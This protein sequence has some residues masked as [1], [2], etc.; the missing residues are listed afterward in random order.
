[1]Q[2]E[3]RPICR[4]KKCL[5]TIEA[6]A[7]PWFS[8]DKSI[9]QIGISTPPGCDFTQLCYMGSLMSATFEPKTAVHV[10]SN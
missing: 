1:M 5:H 6:S 2:S 4:V 7:Y 3:E 8:V 9:I 10:C